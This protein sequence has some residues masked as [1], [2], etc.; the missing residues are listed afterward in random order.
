V[1]QSQGSNVPRG[2]ADFELPVTFR[3]WNFAK[4][5]I[6][7][8]I[9]SGALLWLNLVSS[10]SLE[11]LGIGLQAATIAATV[12]FATSWLTAV[13]HV[14]FDGVRL[15]DLT[16]RT[17]IGWDDI[18]AFS[19]IDPADRTPFMLNFWP[20]RDQAQLLL[21]S[22][23]SKRVRAIEP[24]HGFTVL[25]LLMIRGVTGADQTVEWLNRFARTRRTFT[26]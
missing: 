17:W 15:R 7:F 11:W 10:W 18:E 21:T 9:L 26:P 23:E 2:P 20:W 19:I 1:L 5:A 16:K 6:A 22:G 8:A 3:N 14:D 12:Y 25:T 4:S 13:L 24:R